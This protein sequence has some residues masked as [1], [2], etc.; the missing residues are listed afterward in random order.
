MKSIENE[1]DR[2]NSQNCFNH[3]MNNQVKLKIIVH[4]R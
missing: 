1:L 4:A 3:I 2:D